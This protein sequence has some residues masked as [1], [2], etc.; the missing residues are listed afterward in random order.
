MIDREGAV[1]RRWPHTDIKKSPQSASKAE[2]VLADVR[3]GLS[4]AINMVLAFSL[5][6]APGLVPA[7]RVTFICGAK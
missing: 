5:C 7:G 6:T 4:I 2:A 1:A 3:P